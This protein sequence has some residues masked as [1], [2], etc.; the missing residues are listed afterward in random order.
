MNFSSIT[1]LDYKI[2]LAFLSLYFDIHTGTKFT[3]FIGGGIGASFVSLSLYRQ[4]RYELTGDQSLEGGTWEAMPLLAISERNYKEQSTQ[5]AWHLALGV[6]YSLTDNIDF[7]F[8]YRYIDMGYNK[9]LDLFPGLIHALDG[10]PIS[11]EASGYGKIR[12]GQTEIDMSKAEQI[13]LGVRYSF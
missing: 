11:P 10:K 12:Y 8:M 9:T 1:D 2:N 5:F 6:S 4:N 7:E 3:P 13:L